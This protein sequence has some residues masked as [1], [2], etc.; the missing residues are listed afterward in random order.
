MTAAAFILPEHTGLV[1]GIKRLPFAACERERFI[2][3]TEF[4]DTSIGLFSKR[5]ARMPLAV[6]KHG[7][8]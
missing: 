7:V 4:A 3:G 8:A 5:F 2:Y 6:I 1:Y